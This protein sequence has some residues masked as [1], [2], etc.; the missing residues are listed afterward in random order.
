MNATKTIASPA[1]RFAVTRDPQ[2]LTAK[3]AWL[4]RTL[5][6]MFVAANQ[7]HP[8]SVFSEIEILVALYYGGY[9]RVKPGQPDDPSRDRLIV[10]K[11]HATMGVYPI[12][13]DL[14]FFPAS[15]LQRFGKPEGLLRVF[16]NISI[17]GIDATTGSL[18]HG[19]G[20]GAGY[21]LAA[22][23]DGLDR[24]AIVIISE[25]ELYEGSV[26][27]TALFAAHHRLDN[28]ILVL[29]RNRRIILGDTEDLV[30]LEP[31]A[32]KWEAFGWRAMRADGHSF[33]SLLE[34]FDAACAGDGRPTIIDASTVKGKGVALMENRAEWHYWR[35][36]SDD[37]IKAVRA[38][39]GAV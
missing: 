19:P 22:K 7:G 12:L 26:W 27:E 8:G 5:F 14:G 34:S 10:S 29:D 18:G 24:R 3:A 16:G 13:A 21:A 36:M 17:P 38:E 15:E 20:I 33:P 37:E 32:Q 30:A 31:I 28:L 4:R 23:Q 1:P 9:V 11:G 2:V 39:L 6:E 35:G 25:G